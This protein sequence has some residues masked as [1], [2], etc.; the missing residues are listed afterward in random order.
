ML[1]Q[2]NSNL[3][4]YYFLNPTYQDDFLLS[5]PLLDINIF[6]W[7]RENPTPQKA[8]VV[9]PGERIK[10]WLSQALTRDARL[11]SNSRPAVQISNPLLSRYAIWGQ[12][13]KPRLSQALTRGARLD[14]NSRPAV[15]ISNPLS[16][17]SSP[18]K[19]QPPPITPQL[20]ENPDNKNFLQR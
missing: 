6:F 20:F 15:Q 18:Y 14:S 17:R 12:R 19:P 7:I 10:P 8:H 11:D 3:S 4:L 13:V 9:G 1:N 2:L 5:R 16:S